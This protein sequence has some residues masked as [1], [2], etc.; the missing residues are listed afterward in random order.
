MP[1]YFDLIEAL[2]PDLGTVVCSMWLQFSAQPSFTMSR[3]KR[4]KKT[5]EREGKEEGG[6]PPQAFH[7]LCEFIWFLR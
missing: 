5:S 1:A 3:L 2:E 6:K 4:L 7:L